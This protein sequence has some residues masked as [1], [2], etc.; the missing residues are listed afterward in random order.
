MTAAGALGA[1]LVG[2]AALLLALV[3]VVAARRALREVVE[4]RRRRLVGPLRPVLLRLVAGEPDEAAEADAVLR[5]LDRRRWA[6]VE[7]SVEALMVKVRGETHAAVV[8]LLQAR[9]SLDRARRRCRARS[10]VARCRGAE[11]L[12]ATGRRSALRHLLPLL[13]DREPEVRQVAARAV[14][15]LGDP[16][17]AERLL[18]SLSGDRPVPP[19]IVATAVLRLGA[20][21]E[22]ALADAL[23]SGDPLRRAVAAEIAGLAGALRRAPTL[24]RLLREDP[25][26]EVQVRCARALGRLGTPTALGPLLGAVEPARPT[27]VRTVA[28]RALGDLGDPR[29]VPRL[30]ALME[31]PVHRVA[32]NAAQ[33][34]TRCGPAGRAALEGAAAAAAGAHARD[35]LAVLALR[36]G[37]AARGG[38]R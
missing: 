11:L 19:R 5:A 27:P 2:L 29:A 37:G 14:G 23:A 15:R 38:V 30:L 8:D 21:A 13:A 28:A 33:S 35:A 36:E 31:D 25:E 32:A 24:G 9:G 10:L 22:P 3:L 4:R 20:A 17:G 7:P 18:D 1:A 6:A 16:A 26:T 12:G 34:L